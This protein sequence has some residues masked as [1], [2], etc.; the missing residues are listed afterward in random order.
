M[1]I[2]ALL[3]SEDGREID[4]CLDP[5]MVLPCLLKRLDLSATVCLRYIDPF[6]DTIFNRLQSS[7]LLG[8]LAGI[9]SHLDATEIA[10]IDGVI[11]LAKRV[12][13]GSHLYLAFIGD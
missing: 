3:Q 12:E 4:A 9:R 2:N 6:G 7:T 10:L 8:E 1:G 13:R 5:G 11:L